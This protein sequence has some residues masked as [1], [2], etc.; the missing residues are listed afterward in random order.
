VPAPLQ[1]L[2]SAVLQSTTPVASADGA[3]QTWSF[4]QAVPIPSYLVALCVGNLAKA[5]ISDRCAVWAEP[6]KVEAAAFEFGETEKFLAAAE[7]LCGPYV[8]GRYDLL[9]MPP[10]YP[11]GGMENACLT[12]VTPTLLAGDRSLANVVA[13]EIAH[14]WSGNLVTNKTWESFFLNEGFTVFIERKILE[15]L[16]GGAFK[17]LHSIIGW[18]DLKGSVAQYGADHPFTRLQVCHAK[19]II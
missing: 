13:H 4:N 17:G 14:S 19:R 1:A 8:W 7:E 10:S 11:Y 16:N 2:M 15:K 5:D 18:E 3:L 9:L 12:F 6:E